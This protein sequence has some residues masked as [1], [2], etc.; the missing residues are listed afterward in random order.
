VVQASDPVIDSL[1][2]AIY[3]TVQQIKQTVHADP[4]ERAAIVILSRLKANGSARLSDLA[5]DLMLDISTVS[6]QARALEDR[7]L[8]S[9]TEDPHDRRAVRLDLAPAGREILAAAWARRHDWLAESLADW[10]AE[11]R[12]A[13]TAMLTRFADALSAPPAPERP[14][15]ETTA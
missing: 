1:L 15:M 11:D 5:A 12:I 8:V 7:G 4:V 6:R 3:R 2:Q 10:S 14:T 13:L 9:R